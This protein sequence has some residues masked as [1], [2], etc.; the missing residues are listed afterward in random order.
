MAARCLITCRPCL[1]TQP[2]INMASISGLHTSS[3]LYI[4]FYVFLWHSTRSRLCRTIRC[5]CPPH[6]SRAQADRNTEILQQ[7]PREADRRVFGK[8]L[9]QQ[10]DRLCK[11]DSRLRLPRSLIATKSSWLKVLPRRPRQGKPCNPIFILISLDR[12][13]IGL[14]KIFSCSTLQ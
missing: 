9:W 2:T 5:E 1:M 8:L 12:A 13:I 4:N 11:P 3:A 14:W 7:S 6:C 10:F